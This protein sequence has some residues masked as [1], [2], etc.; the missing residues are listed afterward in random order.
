MK[1]YCN[2]SNYKIYKLIMRHLD[3]KDGN[4]FPLNF[5]FKEHNVIFYKP[6]NILILTSFLECVLSKIQVNIP[7]AILM[8]DRLKLSKICPK[9]I[10]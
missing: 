5:W 9:K 2:S 6:K 1:Y 4:L 7:S 3:K 8:T 10:Y